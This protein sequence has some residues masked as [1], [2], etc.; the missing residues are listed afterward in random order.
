MTRRKQSQNRN[1]LCN[2][3]ASILNDK[4]IAELKNILRDELKQAVREEVKTPLR[5]DLDDR[6][7]I[8]FE[9]PL[10]KMST[11]HDKCLEVEDAINFT[12]HKLGDLCD[13]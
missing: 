11:L 10:N 3:V 13:T 2:A 9:T 5:A 4:F 8:S 1:E 6:R 7:L 12:S